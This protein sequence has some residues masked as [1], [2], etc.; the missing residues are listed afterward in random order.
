MDVVCEVDGVGDVDGVTGSEWKQSSD[1]A[2]GFAD[3][4]GLRD[5]GSVWIY[6][7]SFI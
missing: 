3:L 5:W 7:L 2:E 6:V 4:V 1:F